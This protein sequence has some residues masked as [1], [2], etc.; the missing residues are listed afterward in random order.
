MKNISYE[1]FRDNA[2]NIARFLMKGQYSRRASAEIDYSGSSGDPDPITQTQTRRI[3]ILVRNS[4]EGISMVVGTYLAAS[5]AIIVD[6]DKTP[7]ERINLIFRDAHVYTVL[8]IDKDEEIV[9]LLDSAFSVYAW[10]EV[11][12]E[13]KLLEEGNPV[14]INA[15]SNEDHPFAIYYTR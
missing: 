4:S 7:L 3:G 2:K 6:I 15:P 12:E 9:K 5:T 11:I 1:E 8:V 10:R 14:C 13:D